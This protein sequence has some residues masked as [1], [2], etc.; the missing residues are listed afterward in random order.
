MN[1]AWFGD[2]FHIFN[3]NELK[4]EVKIDTPTSASHLYLKNMKT[5]TGGLQHSNSPN[6]S[7]IPVSPAYGIYVS[8]LS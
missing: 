8:K 5:N 7:N 1:N 6:D 2:Y 3:Q 4:I